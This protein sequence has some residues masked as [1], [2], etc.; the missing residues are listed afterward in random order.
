MKKRLLL[1]LS[2]SVILL[3]SACGKQM[4]SSDEQTSEPTTVEAEATSET[5]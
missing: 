1:V 3:M 5:I 4:V 2:I